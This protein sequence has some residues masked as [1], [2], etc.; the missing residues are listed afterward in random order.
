[1]EQQEQQLENEVAKLHVSGSPEEAT[2]V[3][4]D[5]DEVV[6]SGQP[7][8]AGA[9]EGEEAKAE[10]KEVEEVPLSPLAELVLEA[11]CGVLREGLIQS[12]MRRHL[13][14][15]APPQDEDGLG[16]EYEP[17]RHLHHHNHDDCDGAA[18]ESSGQPD[19]LSAEQL[20]VID[21]QVTAMRAHARTQKPKLVRQFVKDR[22]TS[23]QFDLSEQVRSV[24]AC[25]CAFVHVR[26]RWTH[27]R[28]RRLIAVEQ[29]DRGD[30]ARGG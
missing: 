29:D 20:R 7:A 11:A 2:K 4:E 14:H 6:V 23:L 13:H 17:T 30:P 12:A 8:A 28:A 24:C 22:L 3:D 27:Q 19:A 26:V 10:E 21:E 16:L 15:R 25:A 1:M 18:G 9:S 5:E